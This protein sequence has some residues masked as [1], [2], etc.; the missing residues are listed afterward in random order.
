M[1]KKMCITALGLLL[2]G[3]VAWPT[4]A[5]DSSK[6]EEGFEK[7][8]DGKTLDGWKVY[9]N[10]GEEVPL[11]ESAWSVKDG[12]I[13]CDGKKSD[14]WIVLPG[15]KHGDL[16]LRFEYKVTDGSNSGLFLK[17]PAVDLP[18]YKG[19][20][21]QIM[22]DHGSEP[23]LHATGSIYDVLAP[24]RNM[25]K[26]D[27]EWNEM[28]VIN[29][30]TR[31]KVKLNGF[32]VIDADLGQLIEPIGKFEFAYSDLPEK[33]YVGFQNHGRELWFRNVRMKAGK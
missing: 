30:G 5:A 18:A 19:Y 1:L 25:N 7:V 24:M 31:V 11:E 10:S 33:G 27:G 22:S 28:E 23:N 3:V 2:V 9:T 32:K 12:E 6:S 13:Y 16:N 29:K 26:P 21:V 15:G 4:S 17:C 20:E 8:F 14:Y